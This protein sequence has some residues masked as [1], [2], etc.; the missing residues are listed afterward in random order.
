MGGQR[1]RQELLGVGKKS[2]QTQQD[3]Q[4]NVQDMEW[5]RLNGMSDPETGEV[6]GEGNE[7]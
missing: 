7:T 1:T 2:E 3:R 4:H 6:P 5:E